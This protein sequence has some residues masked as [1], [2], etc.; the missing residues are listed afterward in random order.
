[1]TFQEIVAALKRFWADQGCLILEPYDVEK[2]AGTMNPAT[3]LR[4]LGPEPWRAAYVEPSRRPVDGR[5]GENPN[6][7]YQHQQFQVVLKPSPDDIQ[8]VY[9]DS[10]AALGFDRKVHDIRFVEDNWEAPTLGAW[11]VG[12]EVWLDNMEVTQ[13]TYFQQAGGLDC[14]PVTVEITYGLERIA[15]YIQGVDSVYDIE[16]A[17]GITYGELFHQNEV[18]QSKYAFDL[19][20]VQMLFSLFN[21]Y[22]SEAQIALK[23]G[24]VFPAYDYVLKASHTFNLLDARGAISVGERSAFIARVRNLARLCAKAFLEQRKAA[25]FPLIREVK[26]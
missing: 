11:G 21:A 1:M 6:R 17:H 3:F 12:W 23:E 16:W 5:Y 18:E 2:G 15:S 25:G 4:V 8:E 20:S 9:L 10:L 14:K 22:E 24:V 13:F 26:S 7:L 19:S